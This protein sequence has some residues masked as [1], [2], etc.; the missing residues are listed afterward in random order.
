MACSGSDDGAVRLWD[1]DTGKVIA[2]WTGHKGRISSVCWNRG[3]QAVSGSYDDGTVRVWDVDS[4]KTILAI[5]TGFSELYAVI[6]SPDMTMIATGGDNNEEDFLKIWDAKTGKL[7]VN[8]KGHT[9]ELTCLAWT[10]DGKTLISG[11]CCS[12]VSPLIRSDN[13]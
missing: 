9:E 11:T 10:A 5:E 1:V 3:G 2:K 7:I 13:R 12:H 8:L 6:Y 4:G